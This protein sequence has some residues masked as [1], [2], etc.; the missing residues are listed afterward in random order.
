MPGSVQAA[1][2][3]TKKSIKVSPF[4]LQKKLPPKFE[5]VKET[6]L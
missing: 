4:D 2:T 5:K 6:P 3:Y 1:L